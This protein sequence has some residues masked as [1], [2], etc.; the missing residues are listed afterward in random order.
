MKKMIH[1]WNKIVEN[2]IS[3]AVALLVVSAGAIV[4]RS[5]MSIDNKIDDA[6]EGVNLQSEALSTAVDVIEAELIKLKE[7]SLVVE[8][9]MAYSYAEPPNEMDEEVPLVLEPSFANEGEPLPEKGYIQ[10]Q[11]PANY[12]IPRGFQ[13]K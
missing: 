3:T 1:N 2:A 11:L 6:L 10:Q 7:Q 13:K 8:E 12:N 9:D 5:A 4:W